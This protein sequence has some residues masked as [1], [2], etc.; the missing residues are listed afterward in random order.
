[1]TALHLTDHARVRLRHRAIPTLAVEALL[2]FGRGEHDNR[3]GAIV[4][5][6]TPAGAWSGI[7]ST[8]HWSAASTPMPSWPA[9]GRLSPWVT[10]TG[11]SG[12]IE[13]RSSRAAVLQRLTFRDEARR[14]GDALLLAFGASF[15]ARHPPPFS[16]AFGLRPARRSRPSR[17]ASRLPASSCSHTRRTRQPSRRSSR[18]TRLSRA[19]FLSTFAAQ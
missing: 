10:A 5:F 12:G 1:M 6:D 19:R 3:G 17:A 4:Y 11:A 14:T 7:A 15:Q 2:A 9:Q 16:S 13:R 18:T 8:A